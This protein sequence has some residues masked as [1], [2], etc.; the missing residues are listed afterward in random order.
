MESKTLRLFVGSLSYETTEGRN[1]HKSSNS[2]I[3]ASLTAYFVRELGIQLAGAIINR[4][5]ENGNSR[6]FGFITFY[7]ENTKDYV[8]R[9]CPHYIDGRRVLLL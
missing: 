4:N 9:H 2:H 1:F 6:G 8:L 5:S 7:D 3:L